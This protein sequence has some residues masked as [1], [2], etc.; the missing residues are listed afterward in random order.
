MTGDE[1]RRPDPRE[2]RLRRRLRDDFLVYAPRCLTIR[3]KD[4]RLAPFAPNAVQRA[5][6]K[7]LEVQRAATGRV[8]ALVLKA[9]QPGVSTYVGGRFYWQVTHRRGVRAFILTHRDQATDNLF[10]MVKRFHDHCPE[11]VKP[12]TKASN[13]RE[14]TFGLL[15]SGYQVGT[16]TAAGVGRADTIQYFHGSEVAYWAQAEAHAAGVLQAVPE[17][18]GTE[19]ILESTANG[20]GG[21][22]H[23]LW[24]AAE[25]GAG[26]FEP[27]FIPW[28]EHGDYRAAPPA[29]WRAPP[30][31]REYGELHGLDAAQ[32]YWAWRKNAELA[33]AAGLGPDEPCW[34]FRQEYPASA[35]EA[36]Q[37]SGVDSLIRPAAALRARRFAVPAQ[38]HA[39][40][41]LG[42]DVARGGGDL[43][44]LIDRQGRRA[45]GRLYERID[46]ADSMEL[47]GLVARAIERL[48]PDICFIDLGAAGAGVYDRLV[49]LGYRRKLVGVHFGARAQDPRR[50]ANKRAEMWGHLRD[51]LEDPGGARI[52]DEDLLQAELCAPRWKLNSNQQIQLEP[53]DRLR[54]RLGRSPDGA[55]ALAL[56]FAQ[57]VRRADGPPRAQRSDHAYDPHRW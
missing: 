54:E 36:F 53:K 41:V 46:C 52:P 6:H 34:R 21:L 30:A 19:I 17:A 33:L 48:E 44:C 24:S 11:P 18:P 29:G 13:A 57:P 4:G 51:W 14:L 31:F 20:L 3:T 12:Q 16:A 27:I 39:P 49:E 22:F 50:Y 43:S 28:Q 55:D 42:I 38:D 5:L 26:A 47:A 7:R 40:L 8:R 32:L 45:G 25:R 9:R 15:D 23:N 35:Q 10:A 2:L 56:T 1:T 37:V